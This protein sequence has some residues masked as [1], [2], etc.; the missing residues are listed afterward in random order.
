MR[1]ITGLLFATAVLASGQAD[2]PTVQFHHLYTYGSK[3]GIHPPGLLN[4]RSATGVLGQGEHPYGI[5]FPVAVAVDPKNQ[6]WITD[7]G[8]S[9]VHVFN[10]AT[11]G[12][13]EIRRLGEIPLAEPSGIA[14]DA[15]GRIYFA[16][17]GNGG[18]FAFDENGEYDRA[19][20]R[21]G[22]S[23]LQRP[24]LVA[25]S[26]NERTVFVAD[27]AQGAI[28]ALNREGELNT[29]I[30]LPADFGA[31]SSMCVIDNQ[32]Y[33]LG[34]GQHAV[35]IFTESGRPAGE[36]S[37]DAIPRPSAFTYDAVSRRFLVADPRWGVVQVFDASGRNVGMFGHP[38][39]GTDQVRRVD[40][41][42]VDRGGRVFL[43]D[44]HNGK[45]V[46]FGELGK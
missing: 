32:V 20:V 29:T 41:L 23:F 44:S 46:V 26:G 39:D 17:A 38:G 24:T 36:R 40:F 30:R 4:R 34:A 31:P 9:S 13:R 10:T 12:Y 14:V 16:D 5:A 45:V 35:S 27:P 8:T 37:W 2:D 19:M 7:A 22:R 6:I 21:P 18:V 3:S 43:V 28:F 11:G 1:K 25:L 15:Q 33:V 42:D